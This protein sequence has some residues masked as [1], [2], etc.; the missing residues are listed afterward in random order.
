VYSRGCDGRDDKEQRIFLWEGLATPKY[1]LRNFL[2]AGLAA[3]VLPN[4]NGASSSHPSTTHQ[5]PAP[6]S[7]HKRHP[8]TTS[9]IPQPPAPTCDRKAASMK[10]MEPGR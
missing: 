6:C 10:A 5:P 9:A 7:N 2:Q 1:S 4:A 3:L 8:A